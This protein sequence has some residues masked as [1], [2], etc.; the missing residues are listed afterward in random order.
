MQGEI[1]FT[2]ANFTSNTDA[3]CYLFIYKSK[4]NNDG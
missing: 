4:T 3:S 1:F 2:N